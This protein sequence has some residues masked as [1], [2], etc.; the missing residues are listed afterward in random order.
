M[1]YVVSDLHGCYEKYIRLLSHL[2]MRKEDTLYILGDIVDR[3]DGGMAILGDLQDRKN[4]VTLRG[5]H[6]DMA[7]IFLKHYAMPG[8]GRGTDRLFE[9][10]RLWLSDGGGATYKAFL[11]LSL[12][13][14]KRVMAFLNSL[15]VY[16]ELTVGDQRFFLAHTVPARKRFLDFDHCRRKDFLWGEPDYDREYREDLRI[17]TGHT[18]TELID[19]DAEGRI[20]QGNR[21]IAI[22]C[23]AVFGQPLG[24]LCLDTMEEIYIE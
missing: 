19:S 10:F 8:D 16:E 6:D 4:V 21:H 15:P 1:T 14:K 7:V 20:W 3:G 9:A 17:I 2:S 23:G 22:D 12:A 11:E 18:P 13:E 5:N 24:C